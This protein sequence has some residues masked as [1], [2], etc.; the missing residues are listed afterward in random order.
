MWIIGGG[1]C[2]AADIHALVDAQESAV[3]LLDSL[4]MRIDGYRTVFRGEPLKERLHLA[5]GRWSRK[6]FVDRQRLRQLD[7]FPPTKDG[8]PNNLF[9]LIEDERQMRV[10][11]NWDPEKPQKIDFY[12]Q[13]TVVAYFKPRTPWL[14]MPFPNFAGQFGL[15]HVQANLGDARRSLR[16]L[17]RDSS[18][19]TVTGKVSIGGHET[20]RISAKHPDTGTGGEYDGTVFEL[21]IDPSVNY[22]IRQMTVHIPNVGPGSSKP[23]PA[24]FE[25]EIVK[26]VPASNGA[27]MPVEMNA[28]LFD[29]GADR[30]AD[31]HVIIASHVTAN[32]PLPPDA[33]DFTFP[34]HARVAEYPPTDGI[35][36]IHI[37]G[38]NNRAIRQIRDYSEITGIKPA[39]IRGGSAWGVTRYLVVFANVA[40]VLVL[41]GYVIRKRLT[42]GAL[43][44]QRGAP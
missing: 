22:M 6:G 38:S 44:G 10:L 4:D 43:D 7:G 1:N 27:F 33:L 12:N 20:W 28:R 30:L 39:D 24:R 41:L 32:A 14:P 25:R 29:I 23:I 9:D 21:F 15:L 37:W 3:A 42:R 17:V 26:F 35:S 18:S 16:E 13:G 2:G 31:N 11:L 36:T 8:L 5:T 40:C 34:E 19:A